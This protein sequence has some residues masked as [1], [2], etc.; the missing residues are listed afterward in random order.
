MFSVKLCSGHQGGSIGWVDPNNSGQIFNRLIR[1]VKFKINLA[2]QCIRFFLIGDPTFRRLGLK[3]L[4]QCG[5]SLMPR[6][7]ILLTASLS[8]VY[9]DERLASDIGKRIE[10]KGLLIGSSSL[11]QLFHPREYISFPNPC[12]YIL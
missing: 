12:P 6:L 4:L 10:H 1:L 3:E 11:V 2:A 7:G 5:L 8:R 9:A